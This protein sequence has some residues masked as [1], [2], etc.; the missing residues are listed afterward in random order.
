[1]ADRELQEQYFFN[2]VDH[3]CVR[4]VR[5]IH[6]CPTISPVP[7]QLIESDLDFGHH[8]IS[9]VSVPKNTVAQ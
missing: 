7:R 5:A 1:M 6:A 9:N 3:P 4:A 2:L 8:V